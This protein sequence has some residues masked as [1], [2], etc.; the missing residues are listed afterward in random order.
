MSR[1]E[2]SAQTGDV[3]LRAQ[4]LANTR[5]T[6][7][8]LSSARL[9]MVVRCALD[10]ATVID[11]FEQN[12]ILATLNGQPAVLLQV[13]STDDM[14]VVKA[15]QAV[16][17]WI[18]ETRPSLPV[19]V[20]LELWSDAAD[21]YENRMELIAESSVLG[22]LLV[23][24][25]LI[26]TLELKV[27]L[28]VTVGIGVSFLGAFALLPANDVSLNLLSTFAFCWFSA[29]W[30]TTRLWWVRV[31][32]TTFINRAEV[33]RRRCGGAFAV[34]RPVIFAVLTTIV[35]FAPWL[36][37]SGVTAQFTRQLSVVITLA[38]VFSLIE[39][40]LILPSH[41]RDMKRNR[42][43]SRNG[44]SGRRGGK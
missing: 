43:Q 1:W 38:L 20:E 29:L 23:F 14:Q 16:K 27:A 44:S 34:S 15:S 42:H 3:Q 33:K 35:A 19:G 18:E 11:G 26:L 9:Q 2:R 7:R 13:K 10:V 12:E 32:I 36:F 4:N 24:L 31:F 28:W 8:K 39:A 6:L 37:L 40:F 5:A 30:W 21:V 17:Q 41:L 25:V 22:L